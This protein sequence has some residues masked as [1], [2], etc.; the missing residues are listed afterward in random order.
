MK[1]KKKKKHKLPKKLKNRRHLQSQKV[2]ILAK[3]KLK[4]RLIPREAQDLVSR[5]RLLRRRVPVATTCAEAGEIPSWMLDG[6]A[7]AVPVA[8][9]VPTGT[10]ESLKRGREEGTTAEES[11][12]SDQPG[13]ESETKAT[14]RATRTKRKKGEEETAKEETGNVFRCDVFHSI[15]YN[16]FLLPFF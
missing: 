7:A 14:R 11:T 5:I 8:V 16:G 6:A 10:S 4:N 3:E 13:A 15:S 12:E 9:P 1:K 2:P